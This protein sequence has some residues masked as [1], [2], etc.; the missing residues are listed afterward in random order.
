MTV[1]LTHAELLVSSGTENKRLNDYI[2]NEIAFDVDVTLRASIM[3]NIPVEYGDIFEKILHDLDDDYSI[4][5]DFSDDTSIMD[6]SNDALL[7]DD[8]SIIEEAAILGINS[9][10]G[11]GENDSIQLISRPRRRRWRRSSSATFT[12]RVEQQRSEAE[13][14]GDFITPQSSSEGGDNENN[15][16]LST[17]MVVTRQDDQDGD[18]NV[19][20]AHQ[21]EEEDKDDDFLNYAEIFVPLKP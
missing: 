3:T 6:S 2:P 17:T 5:S 10:Y 18:K 21:Q 9:S 13:Q 12:R 15:D 19:V 1:L 7:S 4:Q 11:F 8:D 16:E 14:P 20:I